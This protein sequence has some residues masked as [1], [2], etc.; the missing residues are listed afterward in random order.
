[1]TLDI[2]EAIAQH[3]DA[4]KDLYDS[5][6]DLATQE[7]GIQ[8]SRGQEPGEQITQDLEFGINSRLGY[9]HNQLPNRSEWFARSEERLL[10]AE[11]RANAAKDLR[12]G[13]G[14][15]TPSAPGEP[16]EFANVEEN[17]YV[18]KRYHE[19]AEARYLVMRA[20]YRALADIW[21]TL[22]GEDWKPVANNNGTGN[23]SRQSSVTVNR[24]LMKARMQQDNSNDDVT[25]EDDKEEPTQTTS[26]VPITNGG[27]NKREGKAT[28]AVA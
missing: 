17:L 7:T 21:K 18:S 6:M 2:K 4:T 14:V 24:D 23:S 15:D 9:L 22:K 25:V 12:E 28:P 5:L 11:V 27:D 10:T 8:N 26:V 19:V 16:T 20:E 1:M 13:T 3:T